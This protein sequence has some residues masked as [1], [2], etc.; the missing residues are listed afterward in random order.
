MVASVS[1]Y[2]YQVVRSRLQVKFRS[3]HLF[4]PCPMGVLASLQMQVG[5]AANQAY[6]GTVDV[7]VKVTRHEGFLGLYKGL[8]PN[9]IRVL[10]ATCI[11]FAVYESISAWF[12]RNPSLL[13]K[14]Q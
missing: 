11:T 2:P 3:N 12:R 14:D 10:P 7:L 5:S 13:F 8:V 9:I 1:T 6:T 4:F